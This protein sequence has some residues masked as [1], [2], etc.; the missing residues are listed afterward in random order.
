VAVTADTLLTAGRLR[1]RLAKLTDQQAR[2]LTRAWVEAWDALAPAFQLAL[3]EALADG[4]LTAAKV[5][6]SRRLLAALRQSRE[7]LD[8]LAAGLPGMVGQSVADAVL[9]AAETHLAVI[10]SQFPPP[11]TAGPTINLAMVSQAQ[12]DAIVGRTTQQIHATSLPLAP[13]AERA[14]KQ[15]LVQGVAAGANP[16]ETARRIMR[17]V[18]GRFNGGLARAVRIARTETLDAHRAAAQ[19]TEAANRAVLKDWEWHANLDTRTCPACL[20]MHGTRHDLDEPGPN[21]HPN[22]R[23]ARIAVTKSWKELG[24]NVP[25]PAPLTQDAE[26]WFRDLPEKDQR[27][28]LGPA[29]WDA[30][31]KGDLAFGDMAAARSN[32]GWRDSIQVAPA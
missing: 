19:E 29:R 6:R 16:V 5:N 31:N 4:P 3:V 27:A 12:L 22:G 25:E 8:T 26:A 23:C 32:P 1:E 14:M 20:S 28:M 30:W 13:E 17:R 10:G 24:F 7:R 18:E 21:D 11:G 2:D 15:A 9:D